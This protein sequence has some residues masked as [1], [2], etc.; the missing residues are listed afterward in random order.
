[1]GGRRSAFHNVVCGLLVAPPRVLL[2]HRNASRLWAPDRWDA[3]GGHIE[4]G[5]DDLD[6][7]VREMY[8]E[9]GIVIRAQQARLVGRLTGS[10]YDARVFR[11]HRWSGEPRNRAPEEHDRIAWFARAEIGDLQLADPDLGPFLLGALDELLAR[12]DDAP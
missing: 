8:E 11:V 1:M 5:E 12:G 10:D 2:V 9:L 4:A 6:A 7:L 3:P